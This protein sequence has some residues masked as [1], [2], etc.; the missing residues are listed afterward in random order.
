MTPYDLIDMAVANPPYFAP[1]QGWHYSSTGYIIVG[2]I[3]EKITGRPYAD[4]VRSRLV[5]PL[6]L[7]DT[8]VPGR[9]I[10]PG[11]HAH[12]YLPVTRDGE[13]RWVDVSAVNPSLTWA[14]GEM[15]SSNADLNRFFA[16]LLGGRLLNAEQLAAMQTTVPTGRPGEGYGLGLTSLDAPCGVRAWG[17]EG[18]TPGYRTDSFHTIDGRHLTLSANPLSADVEYGIGNLR[19]AVFCPS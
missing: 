4:A 17:H 9:L 6:G 1:G 14:A 11:P 12:G 19:M 3:I 13:V 15:I 8:H 7:R 10:I 2:L 5:G 16:A 18:G